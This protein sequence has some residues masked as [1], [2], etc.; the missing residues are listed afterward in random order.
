MKKLLII[1]VAVLS[2]TSCV[3]Y[4][5]GQSSILVEDAKV[6]VNPLQVDIKVG[7]KIQGSAQWYKIIWNTDKKPSQSSLRA[8]F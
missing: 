8:P 3:S 6:S 7:R 2:L 5:K 4:H 1:S